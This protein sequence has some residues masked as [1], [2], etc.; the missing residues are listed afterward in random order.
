[1]PEDLRRLVDGRDAIHTGKPYGVA[2]APPAHTRAGTSIRMTRG[3]P[4]ADR[5]RAHPAVHVDRAT[6]RQALAV[7][8]IYTTRLEGMTEARSAPV[9]ERPFKHATR[10]DLC[11]RHRWPAGDLV[12]WDN[13]LTLHHATN[14][15]DGHRRLLN[16]TAFARF[17]VP[18]PRAAR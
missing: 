1:M 2:H 11:C 9:L 4:E 8:P 3:D 13:R 18:E 17:V 7:N 15:Y 16:R 10:P 6:G 14:D 12:V 5:E